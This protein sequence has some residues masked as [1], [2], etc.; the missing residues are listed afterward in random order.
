MSSG[1]QDT[2]EKKYGKHA[3]VGEERG[4]D[5]APQRKG[6]NEETEAAGGK[7]IKEG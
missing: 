1:A 7:G 4:E 6:T 2:E 5:K 3:E